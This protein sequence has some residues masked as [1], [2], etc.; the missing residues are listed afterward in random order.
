MHLDLWYNQVDMLVPLMVTHLALQRVSHLAPL[1]LRGFEMETE[2]Y[3][4]MI[5]ISN[6]RV[7]RALKR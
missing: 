2:Y 3:R 1:I 6:S 7:V 4:D 5:I